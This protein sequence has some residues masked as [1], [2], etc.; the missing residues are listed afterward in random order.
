MELWNYPREQKTRLYEIEA[1]QIPIVYNGY[2]DHDPDGLLYVLKKDAES[3]QGG[4]GKFFADASEA[5]KRGAA[6][7]DPCQCR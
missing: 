2:G 6:A 4:M 3:A 1:I 5:G 7:G